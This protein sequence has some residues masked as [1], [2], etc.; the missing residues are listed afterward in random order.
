[1]MAHC[2]N[3]SPGDNHLKPLFDEEGNLKSD[4]PRWFLQQSKLQQ[5]FTRPSANT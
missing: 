4:A 1:M 3:F 2:G 5:G